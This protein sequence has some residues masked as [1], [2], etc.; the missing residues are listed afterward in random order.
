MD[1]SCS[2]RLALCR[3]ERREPDVAKPAFSALIGRLQFLPPVGRTAWLTL[4]MNLLS[5]AGSG[6]TKPFLIIYLHQARGI[7]LGTAGGLLGS[8]G[9]AGIAAL[10]LAGVLTDR[11]GSFKAFAFGQVLGGIGT[12]AF[13][14]ATSPATA[15]VG[16]VLLG[17]S[18]GITTNGLTTL[19]AVIVP[20]EQRSA[21]FGLG[22]TSLNVGTAIG[23]LVAGIAIAVSPPSI[24]AIVFLADGVSFLLLALGL[25]ALERTRPARQTDPPSLTGAPAASYRIVLGDRA[26]IAALVLSTLFWTAALSQTAATFPAWTTGPADSTTVVVGLGFATNTIVLLTS[27]LV[28]IRVL[29]GRLRTTG[30]AAAGALFATAWAVML[31]AIGAGPLVTAIALIEGMAIFAL[32]EAF[33]APTLPALINDLAPNHVRGR[34]NAV[35]NVSSQAGQVLGP[36]LAGALLAAEHGPVLLAVLAA[37]CLTAAA[38]TTLARKLTPRAAN[39]GAMP[40]PATSA[41][42]EGD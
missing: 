14:F 12:A 5:C 7:D 9:L 15:L 27:Q 36:V 11:I 29:R 13:V 20:A 17:A 41:A 21:A 39:L 31:L 34:Y 26:L 22:Y 32:G 38:L 25:L 10:P 18:G 19:L 8:V 35:F 1:G 42:N 2:I 16:C 37:M 3:L 33:L 23:A 4:G 24:Y 6:L 40:K 28:V 30:A